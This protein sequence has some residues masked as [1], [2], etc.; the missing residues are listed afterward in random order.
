MGSAAAALIKLIIT[1]GKGSWFQR[2]GEPPLIRNTDI[3]GGRR[4]QR[5]APT[6]KKKLK[7]TGDGSGDPLLENLEGLDK[8]D[9]KQAQKGWEALSKVKT[10]TLFI[11]STSMIDKTMALFDKTKTLIASLLKEMES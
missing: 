3:K 5:P 7:E 2:I 9:V 1:K 10:M 4:P 8:K 6:F 11:K